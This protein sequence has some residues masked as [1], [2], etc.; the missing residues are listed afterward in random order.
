MVLPEL[1]NGPTD[2]DPGVVKGG[3]TDGSGQRALG[4][5]TIIINQSQCCQMAVL[6]FYFSHL[7]VNIMPPP[8]IFLFISSQFSCFKS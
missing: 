3:E 8:P 7:A 1:Q 6:S 2:A 5:H 4:N